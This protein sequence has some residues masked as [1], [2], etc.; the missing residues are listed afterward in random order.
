M[1]QKSNK[2]AKL[3]RSRYSLFTDDL[4]HCYICKLREYINSADDMHELFRGRNRQNSM[5]WGLCIPICR[6]HHNKVTNNTELETKWKKLG[7]QMWM[8]YYKGTIE[9][10][11]DIFGRNYL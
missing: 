3:E 5:K 2:L 11:I 1:K 4:E 10:F 9:E 7:Q 6:E 8:E